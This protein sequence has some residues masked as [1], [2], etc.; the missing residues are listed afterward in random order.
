MRL[1]L[2]D[3]PVAYSAAFKAVL[4][5]VVIIG[6]VT[7][8]GEQVAALSVAF[9]AILGVLVFASVQPNARVEAKVEAAA[10]AATNAAL[11]DV[12]S[13]TAEPTSV[14][15]VTVQATDPKKAAAAVTKA[16][17]AAAKKGRTA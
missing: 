17:A 3:Q 14:V 12:A 8:S 4:A 10:D 5:A 16:V 15:N 6:A 1:R 9:D 13:L 2:S 7:L 11:A